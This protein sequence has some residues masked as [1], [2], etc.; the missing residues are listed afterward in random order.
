MSYGSKLLAG[1][2]KTAA[3]KR[4]VHFYSKPMQRAVSLVNNSLTHELSSPAPLRDRIEAWAM[5]VYAREFPGLKFVHTDS[6]NEADMIIFEAEF[7]PNS[8]N[9]KSRTETELRATAATSM[10]ANINGKKRALITL[11]TAGNPWFKQAIE[12]GRGEIVRATLLNE[13]FNGLAVDDYQSLDL[14]KLKDR[15]AYE[16]WL[17]YIKSQGKTVDDFT[18]TRSGGPMDDEK[19]KALDKVIIGRIE[20]EVGVDK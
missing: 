2:D 18:V 13:F 1:L 9:K 12:S 5:E 19:I 15:K 6:E 4:V 20:G 14:S 17:A 3:G 11:N 8:K 10:L 16:E 7:K